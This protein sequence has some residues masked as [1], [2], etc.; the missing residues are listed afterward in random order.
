VILSEDIKNKIKESNTGKIKPM[1]MGNLNPACRNEVRKKISKTQKESGRY[2]GEKNPMF[3]KTHSPETIQ[4]I[5][6]HR[7]MNKLE[8]L[9]ANELDKAS[10][11]YHF[12][13]FINENGVCKSYDFKIKDKPIIIE[14]DGD[15]W[16]G[17][18][19]KSN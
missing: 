16:H 6:S 4:K 9:V 7:K 12:Q 3:G 18:P 17:N 11:P 19:N 10:I 13:Y 5:F 14:V 8:K 15:F 2:I 1:I